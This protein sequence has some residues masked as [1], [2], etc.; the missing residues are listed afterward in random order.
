MLGGQHLEEYRDTGTIFKMITAFRNDGMIEFDVAS[1]A[2]SAGEGGVEGGD[3]LEGVDG[4]ERDAVA[5]EEAAMDEFRAKY[6]EGEMEVVRNLSTSLLHSPFSHHPYSVPRS[7]RPNILV[8]HTKYRAPRNERSTSLRFLFLLCSIAL[9]LCFHLS[10][11]I[12]SSLVLGPLD[13]FLLQRYDLPL[14]V[15][16]VPQSQNS[17]ALVPL[18]FNDSQVLPRIICS[19]SSLYCSPAQ[20]HIF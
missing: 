14:P 15:F 18:P 6:H 11:V 9:P 12:H 8:P 2:M 10:C 5:E 7:H 16:L 20:I 13:V 3:V 1:G 4:V 17:R 19:S